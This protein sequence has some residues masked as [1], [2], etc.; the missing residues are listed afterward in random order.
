MKSKALVA[1][2]LA[3]IYEIG[4]CQR[5]FFAHLV[6]LIF[7]IRGRLNFIQMGRYGIY[8]EGTYRENFKKAFNFQLFNR[9][10]IESQGSGHYVVTFDPSHIKK[11]GSKTFGVGYF[12][13]GCDSKIKRGLEFG[14]FAVC[15]IDNHTAFHL[16]GFQTPNKEQLVEKG[17]TLLAHYSELWIKEAENLSKFSAYGVVD[18]YFSKITFIEPVCTQTGIHII[19]RLR[20]DAV[21][22]YLYTGLPSGKPGKPRQFDGKII[23]KKPDLSHFTCVHQDKEL[24]IYEAVVYAK[25]LKRKVKLALTQ[26]FDDKGNIKTTKLYFCTDVNLA[27]W[28]IVKYYKNRFQQEFLYRDGN[29]FTGLEDCQARSKEK[30]HYHLNTAL[31][32]VSVAKAA[33]YLPLSTEKRKTFSMASVKVLYHNE[34]LLEKFINVFGISPELAYKNTNIDQIIKFGLIDQDI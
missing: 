11:S 25:A 21:L 19:S 31:T 27:G 1:A 12:W 17:Q 15:D 30:L 34:L 18:A 29:Q 16:E 13:S 33:H 8:N 28:Y 9:T 20:D 22:Y 26:Y 6:V 5:N 3:K 7:Q 14:G 23:A 32:A 2:I 10:L 4:K 24:R